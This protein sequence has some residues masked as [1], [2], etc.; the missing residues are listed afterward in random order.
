[1]NDKLP[2][3]PAGGLPVNN[4]DQ[5]FTPPASSPRER[6]GRILNPVPAATPSPAVS[7]TAPEA[8]PA[9]AEQP[10][11]EPTARVVDGEPAPKK[12]PA[13][14]TGRQ[15]IIVYM[16]RE[17][18]DWLRRAAAGSTQ[19]NVVLDAVE[20]AEDN[21]QLGRMVAEAEQPDTS[22]LF[23]RPSATKGSRA[24]IQVALSA[25]PSHIDVLNELTAKHNAPDRSALIRAALTYAR[26]HPRKHRA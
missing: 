25:L 22:G 2:E 12:A 26:Q 5:V 4:L 6:L 3:L 23:E 10:T 18:R 1:M 15:V 9:P 24:H 11:A 13:R 8:P 21:D 19:L 17:Q 20:Q 7:P 14:R 16:P